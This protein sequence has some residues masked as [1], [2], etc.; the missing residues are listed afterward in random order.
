MSTDSEPTAPDS[1]LSE[2]RFAITMVREIRITH[3]YAPYNIELDI[4]AANP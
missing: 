1:D 2:A 3:G 4:T